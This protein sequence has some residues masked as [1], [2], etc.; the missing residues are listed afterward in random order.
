MNTMQRKLNK[1]TKKLVKMKA[2]NRSYREI[3]TILKDLAK[4]IGK[5]CGI[6]VR[7]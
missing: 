7:F 6:K 3:R 1:T 5:D 2:I 4:Q